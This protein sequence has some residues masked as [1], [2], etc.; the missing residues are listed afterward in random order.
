MTAP[1]LLCYV[2]IT[3]PK[4]LSVRLLLLLPPSCRHA[5]GASGRG[6]RAAAGHTLPW[7][8]PQ[9]QR[10]QVRVLLCL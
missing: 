3:V 10:Q 1:L 9:P 4:T 2:L 7:R 6:G 5:A 8:H